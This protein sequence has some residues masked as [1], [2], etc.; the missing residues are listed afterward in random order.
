[1]LV[2]ACFPRHPDGGEAEALIEVASEIGKNTR[3]ER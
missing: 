2:V 3:R 1:M